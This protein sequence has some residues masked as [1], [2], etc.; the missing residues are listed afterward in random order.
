MANV[1]YLTVKGNKQ[2][3]ISAG[4]SSY[5]SIGNKYQDGHKDQILVY[6]IDHTLNRSQNVSHSPIILNKPIDKSSPLLGVA[7]STNEIIEC[8]FDI[9]RNSSTGRLEHFYSIKLTNASIKNISIHYPNSLTH[10]DRQ[11]YESIS[12][13]YESITWQHKIAGTSGYCIQNIY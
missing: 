3:L 9:Y 2:G 12:I 5:E 10:N 1:I 7:I 11:P 6:S 8:V 13:A 4:C